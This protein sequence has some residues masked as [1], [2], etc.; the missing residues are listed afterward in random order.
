MPHF[1][2]ED[3]ADFGWT[4]GGGME[5]LVY[6][7]V[8]FPAGV[9]AGTVAYWTRV[10]DAL[11]PHILGGLHT[12]WCWGY[13][14]RSIRDTRDPSFHDYGLAVDINAP[15]NPSGGTFGTG[16]Y[17][18]PSAAPALL[19]PLG[20]ECGGTWTAATPRDPMHLQCMLSPGELTA[21]MAGTHSKASTYGP[22][23][24]G[25]PGSRTI[26]QGARGVDVADL[27]RILNAWYPSRPTL[28]ADGL[29]GSATRAAV[30]YLQG[31]AHLVVD[32]IVGPKTWAALHV[33]AR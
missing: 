26:E 5:K 15:A 23:Y 30:E 6:H 19:R 14:D 10:L 33:G 24:S 22:Y 11:V 29:F 28:S 7:G 16:H 31:K 25:K 20:I 21:L 13:D 17:Q 18:V 12:G 27:Q 32:G 8:P 2:V 3:P 4:L 9:R 1:G